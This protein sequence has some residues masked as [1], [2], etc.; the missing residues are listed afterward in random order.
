MTAGA[1]AKHGPGLGRN[2]RSSQYG[3]DNP[4]DDTT[5]LKSP[6]RRWGGHHGGAEHHKRRVLANRHL[7]DDRG[8]DVDATDE[9]VSDPGADTRVE[10]VRRTLTPG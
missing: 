4:E 5:K 6:R 8:L 2:P 9:Q 7:S 10:V 3:A 1:A